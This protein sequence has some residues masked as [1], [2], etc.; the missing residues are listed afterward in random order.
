LTT[1]NASF[2]RRDMASR[3]C[4]ATAAR[5]WTVNL[6]AVG[7]HPGQAAKALS[8]IKIVFVGGARHA[9]MLVSQ[10]C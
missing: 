9:N 5:M 3:S 4:S 7:L 8:R 2:V 10:G 6:L 1:A